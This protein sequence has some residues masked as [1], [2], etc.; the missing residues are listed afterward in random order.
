MRLINI[1]SNILS[2][3]LYKSTPQGTGTLVLGRFDFICGATSQD[4]IYV[5]IVIGALARSVVTW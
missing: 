5:A 3:P 2:D 1:Q 4:S